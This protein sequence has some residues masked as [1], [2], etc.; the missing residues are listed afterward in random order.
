MG[1]VLCIPAACPPRIESSNQMR[2]CNIQ[3]PRVSVDFQP[4]PKRITASAVVRGEQM[5]GG[6]IKKTEQMKIKSKSQSVI[7]PLC[8]RRVVIDAPHVL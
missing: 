8:L 7:K 1:P 6:T 5:R 4:R 3:P 2:F